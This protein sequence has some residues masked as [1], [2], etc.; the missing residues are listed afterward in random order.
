MPFA[1]PGFH[2]PIPKAERRTRRSPGTPGR[3]HHKVPQLQEGRQEK[4]FMGDKDWQ[5]RH[6]PVR[7]LIIESHASPI[8]RVQPEFA[9]IFP[10]TLTASVSG[11]GP[12]TQTHPRRCPS[13]PHQQEVDG[14]RV[15]GGLVAQASKKASQPPQKKLL[16]AGS[17]KGKLRAIMR[18]SGVSTPPHRFL[19]KHYRCSPLPVWILT[20]RTHIHK[21]EEKWQKL[22]HPPADRS[23]V[24][25]LEA[26]K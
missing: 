26:A 6:H 22:S 20:H 16:P 21:H 9:L 11:S 5:F 25:T 4:I 17:H 7:K 14:L 2:H 12:A 13:P 24:S 18:C 8:S 15:L 10:R 23:T 19:C 3:Q 1:P